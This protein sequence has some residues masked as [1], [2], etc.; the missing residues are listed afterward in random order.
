MNYMKNE[1]SNHARNAI[2]WNFAESQ[3]GNYY[4]QLEIVNEDLDRVETE[5]EKYNE[6]MTNSL[7]ISF[8]NELH[9]SR[10]TIQKTYEEGT[11]PKVLETFER[12][13]ALEK[14]L[15]ILVKHKNKK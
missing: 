1:N 12:I 4:V 3:P 13:S 14:S 7:Y 15:K 9:N 10:E 6:M 2:T 11:D 5:I 8:L